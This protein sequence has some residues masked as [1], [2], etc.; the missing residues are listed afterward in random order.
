M[1]PIPKCDSTIL[2]DARTKAT[3]FQGYSSEDT[4]TEIL[5]AFKVAVMLN[6]LELYSWQLD[7][8]KALEP[9][10]DVTTVLFKMG[11]AKGLSVIKSVIYKALTA[12]ASSGFLIQTSL[13]QHMQIGLEGIHT[14]LDAS[15]QGSTTCSRTFPTH[16]FPCLRSKRYIG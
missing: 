11:I 3:N 2:Q 10:S 16:H 4:C 6:R 12:R 14:P 8:C 1:Y 15:P 7:V 5:S 13:L 9:Y